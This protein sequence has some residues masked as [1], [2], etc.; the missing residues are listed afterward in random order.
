MRNGVEAFGS[1]PKGMGVH[2]GGARPVKQPPIIIVMIIITISLITII[3]IT[4]P[5][6]GAKSNTPHVHSVY[7]VPEMRSRATPVA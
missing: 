3:V 4:V 7:H 1:L 5:V 2:P 6:S